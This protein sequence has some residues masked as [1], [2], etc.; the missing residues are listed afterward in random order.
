MTLCGERFNYYILSQN[1]IIIC[2]FP[3]KNWADDV[4]QFESETTTNYYI[5]LLAVKHRQEKIH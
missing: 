2:N 1:K 4:G 3:A 5:I